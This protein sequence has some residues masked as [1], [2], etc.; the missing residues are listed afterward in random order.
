MLL[1]DESR[2]VQQ[3]AVRDYLQGEIAPHRPAGT[4]TTILRPGSEGLAAPL[5]LHQLLMV[6][7]LSPPSS[8]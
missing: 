6:R 7:R 3:E 4:R 8:P 1:S 5:P 2:A